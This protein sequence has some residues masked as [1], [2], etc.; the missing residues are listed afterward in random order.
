MKHVIYTLLLMIRIFRRRRRKN[1]PKAW[2]KRMQNDVTIKWFFNETKC[3]FRLF[4]VL[5]SFLSQLQDEKIERRKNEE[6]LAVWLSSEEE[7]KNERNLFTRKCNFSSEQ[8]SLV[9]RIVDCLISWRVFS[10]VFF[11]KVLGCVKT[12][13]FDIPNPFQA[14]TQTHQK[15]F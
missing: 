5:C 9:E 6:I 13:I 12:D 3:S 11:F 1:K 7:K 10:S 8:I 4:V 2:T 14:H 15:K